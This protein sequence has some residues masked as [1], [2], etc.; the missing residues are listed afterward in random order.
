MK[1]VKEI[2]AIMHKTY[3]KYADKVNTFTVKEEKTFNVS[4]MT[5][6]ELNQYH[7]EGRFPAHA[8]LDYVD[9]HSYGAEMC[10][11]VERPLTEQE[12]MLAI[13]RKLNLYAFGKVGS[14]LKEKGYY[15]TSVSLTQIDYPLTV[16]Q[17]YRRGRFNELATYFEA[18]WVKS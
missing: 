13:D 11:T 8:E 4:G 12:K 17:M 2:T 15:R 1:Y 3:Q 18:H 5:F 14:F 6:S 7:Q 10:W 16:A 9:D